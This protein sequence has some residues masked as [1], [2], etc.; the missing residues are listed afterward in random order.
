LSVGS[1]GNGRGW[2]EVCKRRIRRSGA[3]VTTRLPARLHGTMQTPFADS[4]G[5]PW[6]EVSILFTTDKSASRGTSGAA[7]SSIYSRR[8]PR[9]HHLEFKTLLRFRRQRLR[10]GG[11][12]NPSGAWARE[13]LVETNA[14][15][16][17]QPIPPPRE[18]ARRL[19]RRTFGPAGRRDMKTIAASFILLPAFSQFARDHRVRRA[20]C[21]I[22]DRGGVKANK[23]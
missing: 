4:V 15:E 22:F 17:D 14:V 1:S 10:G 18:S 13:G 16:R 12:K 9:L 19:P 2:N 23:K 5:R 3:R 20:R 6:S 8:N 7:S 11:N 21:M